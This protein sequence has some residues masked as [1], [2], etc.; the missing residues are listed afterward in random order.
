MALEVVFFA[1]GWYPG[2]LRVVLDAKVN[3]G[4][5]GGLRVDVIWWS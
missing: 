2:S 3:A 4:R 5:F 1:K